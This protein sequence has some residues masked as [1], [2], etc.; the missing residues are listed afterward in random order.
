M[1]AKLV[2]EDGGIK[3]IESNVATIDQIDQGIEDFGLFTN[4]IAETEMLFTLDQGK[5]LSS[6]SRLSRFSLR[7]VWLSCYWLTVPI[8]SL[9]RQW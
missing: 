4:V 9:M 2:G 3:P 1:L 8:R 7:H 6:R 5:C